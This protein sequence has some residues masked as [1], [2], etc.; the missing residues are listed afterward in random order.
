VGDNGTG[1]PNGARGG[2][3]S[4]KG[5]FPTVEILYVAGIGIHQTYL[6]QGPP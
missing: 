1:G 3:Q 4:R 6:Q 5:R 2:G